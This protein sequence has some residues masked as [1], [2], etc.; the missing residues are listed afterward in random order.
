MA[1]KSQAMKYA[2]MLALSLIVWFTGS[3]QLK[4][5]TLASE[6]SKD[7]SAVEQDVRSNLA[8]EGFEVI[9]SYSPSTE[10]ERRVLIITREDLLS[11]VSDLGGLNGFMSAL[12][13]GITRENGVS[14][15][16]YTTPEYWGNAYLRSSYEQ[17]EA[18]V[19]SVQN[20]LTSALSDGTESQFGSKSGLE[21][22]KLRKYKY[23]MGMPRF[24]DTELLATFDS[25]TQAV[26]TIESNIEKSTDNIELVYSIP[27]P[28]SD[29]VLYGFGLAGEEGEGSFM[30]VIDLTSPRHTAF[31]P[32]EM[33]VSGNEVHM[34]HGRYRIALSFPDLK[35]GTFMKIVSTPKDIKSQLGAI[36]TSQPGQ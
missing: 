35:M 26:Q 22:E 33:L 8:A 27:L 7:L 16:S 25:H 6:S 19:K 9:G 24:E 5:Y 32:Y 4:P 30:P 14:S 3:A 13:V 23:M 11:M 2:L 29:Q 34:L 12:R 1:I 36:A 17:V 10:I 21:A 20:D 31:L 15:V 18:L 28:D